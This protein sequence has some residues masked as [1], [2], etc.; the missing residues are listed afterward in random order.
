MVQI[1]PKVIFTFPSTISEKTKK[2]VKSKHVNNNKVEKIYK[3]SLDSIPSPSPSLKIQII[4]GKVCLRCKGKTLLG[5][6]NK[7]LNTIAQQC[8]AFTTQANF[9]AHNLNLH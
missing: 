2:I 1:I 9:P 8:F 4:G 5:D 6:V 7:L 3:D